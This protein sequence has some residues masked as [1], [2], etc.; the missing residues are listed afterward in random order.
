METSQLSAA[1]STDTEDWTLLE[2]TTALQNNPK[3]TVDKSPTDD[4]VDEAG[5]TAAS[6]T[7]E[8]QEGG[9]DAGLLKTTTRRRRLNS[10]R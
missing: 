8:C 4:E 1:S 3:I 7:E 9:V 5:I 10:H 6:N 2:S